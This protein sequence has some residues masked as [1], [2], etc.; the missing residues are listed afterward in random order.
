MQA[1]ALGRD[2]RSAEP[3]AVEEEDMELPALAAVCAL[4]PAGASGGEKAGGPERKAERKACA[5]TSQQVRFGLVPAAE[6]V[7]TSTA[8]A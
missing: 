3:L 7:P 5:P 4:Q 2:V 1:F 8:S 6:Q